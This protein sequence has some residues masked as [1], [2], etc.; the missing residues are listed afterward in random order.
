MKPA[1]T[2]RSDSSSPWI[3]PTLGTNSEAD[4]ST[5]LESSCVLL[6]D[7]RE[8]FRYAV[9]TDL[10]RHAVQVLAA[11]GAYDAWHLAHHRHIDLIVL[12][13]NLASQSGWQCAAKLC[14][15][16][17]WRGVVMHFDKV[18]NVDRNWR[19]AA[20]LAALVETGGRPESVV[21]CVLRVLNNFPLAHESSTARPLSIAAR[22]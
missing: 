22:S 1:Q 9:A 21:Q 4:R 14:G 16:P 10:Q 3:S 18:S 2:Y 5:T 17:P 11:T 7:D 20:G 6:V 8:A 19:L 15:R 13:G 12:R